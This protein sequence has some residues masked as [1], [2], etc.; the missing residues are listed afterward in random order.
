MYPSKQSLVLGIISVFAV[1]RMIQSKCQ[2]GDVLWRKAD[3]GRST[4]MMKHFE[5]SRRHTAHLEINWSTSMLIGCVHGR[6]THY[7]NADMHCTNTQ[8]HGST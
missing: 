2:F 3:P 4:L 1:C 5:L 7:I 6:L 8:E